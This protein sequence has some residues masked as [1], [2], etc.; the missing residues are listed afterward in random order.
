MT[1]GE[2]SVSVEEED[3]EEAR[4]MPTISEEDTNSDA[5]VTV[6]PKR[7]KGIS[8]RFQQVSPSQVD[9]IKRWHFFLR[10]RRKSKIPHTPECKIPSSHSF[11]SAKPSLSLFLSR[12]TLSQRVAIVL[13]FAGW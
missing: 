1:H 2:A 6:R 3:E 8:L 9:P 12:V 10:T 5:G 11:T 7:R 13:R 4:V